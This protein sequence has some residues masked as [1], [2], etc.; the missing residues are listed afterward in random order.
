MNLNM[1]ENPFTKEF[2]SSLLDFAATKYDFDRMICLEANANEIHL[3]SNQSIDPSYPPIV[4]SFFPSIPLEPIAKNDIDSLDLGI[5]LI[6]LVVGGVALLLN[7]FRIRRLA[8]RSKL[9]FDPNDDVVTLPSVSDG[10]TFMDRLRLPSGS[11][12]T[13]LGCFVVFAVAVLETAAHVLARKW[14]AHD[15]NAWGAIVTLETGIVAILF[16]LVILII[17]KEDGTS[18]RTISGREI[19]LK[20]AAAFPA[21]IALLFLLFFFA[22]GNG[23]V[24]A[25]MIAAISIVITIY[26]VFR[27]LEA[28][29]SVEIR[30]KVS[31]EL[32]RAKVMSVTSR[33]LA[34]RIAYNWTR[35]AVV[36]RNPD[37]E[38]KPLL[39]ER[40][41]LAEDKKVQLKVR[42]DRSGVITSIDVGR[43][44]TLAERI[45]SI[46]SYTAT[47]QDAATIV[48][49]EEDDPQVVISVGRY[50]GTA[51]SV[52]SDILAEIQYPKS[53][54][55]SGKEDDFRR[56][57]LKSFTI[58]EL[59][60][61][62][63]HEALDTLMSNISQGARTGVREDDLEAVRWASRAFVDV[64][65]S[66]I[67]K[68]KAVDIRYDVTSAQRESPVWGFSWEP[69]QLLVSQLRD[70][71]RYS[72]RSG[73]KDHKTVEMVLYIPY[74]L[75]VLS[76]QRR[77][78]LGLTDFVRLAVDEVYWVTRL[79]SATLP[80]LISL[81]WLE[82]LTK[83]Y[84]MHDLEHASGQNRKELL[85]FYRV[86]FAT[87]QEIG[88]IVVR[89]RF[90]H[91]D[92]DFSKKQ[93][94]RGRQW[95][96]RKGSNKVVYDR[97]IDEVVKLLHKLSNI[98]KYEDFESQRLMLDFAK[99]QGNPDIA[100]GNMLDEKVD[101]YETLKR[102]TRESLIG[103]ISY[104][105]K[106]IEKAKGQGAKES[107]A[108]SCM[109]TVVRRLLNSDF[110]SLNDVLRLYV[111]FHQKER[112]EEW[113]WLHW[114]SEDQPPEVAFVSRTSDYVERA[115]A[116]LVFNSI[117][118]EQV[119]ID[120]T[121]AEKITRASHLFKDTNQ[122]LGKAIK[123]VFPDVELFEIRS[124]SLESVEKLQRQLKDVAAQADHLLQK[125][126]AREPLSTEK[127]E[128]FKIAFEQKFKERSRLRKVLTK[129]CRIES[130]PRDDFWGLNL[131]VEREIFIDK[132]HVHYSDMG[133][134][135]G[136]DLGGAEDQ[137]LFGKL[138][139]AGTR[140]TA[141]VGIVATLLG[142]AERGIDLSNIV[143]IA[144]RDPDLYQ[145]IRSEDYVL[146]DRRSRKP[147]SPHDGYLRINSH[148]VPVITVWIPEEEEDA[149][150]IVDRSKVSIAY[151]LDQAWGTIIAKTFNF[152]IRDPQT[153]PNTAAKIVAA[154]PQW[155]DFPQEDLNEMAALR[156][157]LRIIE[158]VRLDIEVVDAV[159]VISL[160]NQE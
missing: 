19:L 71:I 160:S 144:S 150:L 73:A 120:H 134:H 20:H 96:G 80:R 38:F 108:V 131:L 22:I 39:G 113:G 23:I 54:K 83:Y 12:L 75:S 110:G 151:V 114:E 148:E 143:V 13:S 26:V 65:E 72:I 5:R 30:T 84:L 157:W 6:F 4:G 2:E 82:S 50:V 43:L 128:K 123:D 92:A 122:W 130:N 153:D 78:A 154:A 56:E 141:D 102:W 33:N 7:F 35:L 95:N 53:E 24:S 117:A 137:M 126:I 135:F 140:V 74:H 16:P 97:H 61:A 46:A 1:N 47:S 51:V 21:S 149:V 145:W 70:L 156:V 124:L 88:R 81:D 60:G 14:N 121:I 29:Y 155:L 93:R 116:L 139:D 18:K 91:C 42:S 109:V 100:A 87:I 59:H 86:I 85:S 55:L 125:E 115:F 111:D 49:S 66:F 103:L 142:L 58:I 136:S 3:A 90:A 40:S 77:E 105:L 129:Y 8:K 127:I 25:K 94:G 68:L 152:D 133:A 32:L 79:E 36:A 48:P 158:I 15:P 9:D 119:A 99:R 17:S 28:T 11:G 146:V 31:R 45:R 34:S 147:E 63:H 112:D 52:N 159:S 107:G 101:S 132:P 10:S 41:N 106:K 57:A 67:D 37:L 62:L 89:L 64:Y 138:R 98:F 104:C 44:R 118:A 27:L 76:V 69:Q